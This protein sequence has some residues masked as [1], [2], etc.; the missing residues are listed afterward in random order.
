MNEI[1]KILSKSPEERSEGDLNYIKLHK[2]ELTPEQ[3]NQIHEERKALMKKKTEDRE[4]IRKEFTVKANALEDNEVEVI[5]N[6]GGVDRH[7]EQIVIDGVDTKNYMKNPVV[8][9]A[10]DYSLP[11]IGKT[12]KIWT[13]GKKMMARMKFAV[14]ENPFAKQI[15][16]LVKGGFISAVSIGFIAG[17]SEDMNDDD[18]EFFWFP[19]QK[20]LTSEMIEFSFVPIPAD[21]KALVAAKK[22]G[23]DTKLF[24]NYAGYTSMKY[25]LKTVIEKAEKDL[26]S[27]TIG[28]IKFLQDNIDGLT[29]K[30]VSQFASVLKDG[31]GEG[32]ETPKTEDPK[33]EDP[34]EDPKKEDEDKKDE[35]VKALAD[36]V[37]KLESQEPVIIKNIGGQRTKVAGTRVDTNVSKQ[38]KFLAYIK[39][40]QS[41]NFQEFEN[42]VGKDAMNTTSDGQVLPPAEFIVDLERL[43]EEVGVALRDANVRRS[44]KE[45]GLKYVLGDDDVE[46]F[47]TSEGGFKKSTKIS[48]QNL[49]L[50]WRKWAAILPI[51]DELSEGAAFDIWDDAMRRFSRAR[52]K[53]ADVLVFTNQASGGKTKNGIIHASG[54]NN[55]W[56]D[57]LDD[58]LD[59][60]SDSYAALVDMIYGVPSA[61]GNTGKFYMNREMVGLIMKMKDKDG[62]PLWL[63]AVADGKPATFLNRPYEEVEVLPGV[64]ATGEGV[65]HM[66]YGNLKYATLGIRNDL[67]MKMFDTGIV[68]DPDED[69]QEA[70]TLNLLT[71]DMQ[72]LRTVYRMNAVVRFPEAFSVLKIGN[73]S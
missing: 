37:K 33:T 39:G 45:A 69:D 19:P 13:E 31:E 61:S 34:K 4:Q 71:Q 28:E 63:P 67:R 15:Y 21:P 41:G 47:E 26:D 18:D 70:N 10:H 52:A 64:N 35:D 9:W 32:T 55:V 27:L 30:Q 72:A 59:A 8:Q 50:E 6:S 68:G 36:R 56:I 20:Y 29:R 66:V 22:L 44:D 24:S 51:T 14:E 60:D 48:Y 23:I 7:G 40:V 53:R 17:E 1:E 62:R 46:D 12:L 57:S 16:E 58:L 73:G 5:V 65:A 54:V 49:L 2:N 11:P 38:L 3:L 42:L 43:E 25:E